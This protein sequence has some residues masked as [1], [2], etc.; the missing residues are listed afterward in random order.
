MLHN[1]GN[2]IFMGVVNVI[3]Q[4]R[5]EAESSLCTE[6]PVVC[7]ICVISVGRWRPESVLR[8]TLAAYM[9]P[10]FHIFVT[11]SK[12]I[13][14]TL[15][16]NKFTKKCACLAPVVQMPI[17]LVLIVTKLIIFLFE[18]SFL[19]NMDFFTCIQ[20]PFQKLHSN[21]SVL[22]STIYF[23]QIQKLQELHLI[24]RANNIK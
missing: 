14:L 10:C 17:T 22:S 12:Y 21:I 20:L 19:S 24:I 18:I 15:S 11:P 9:Q 23:E 16:L 13:E 4:Q 6:F 8:C 2:K 5:C 3:R 1:Y 7:L